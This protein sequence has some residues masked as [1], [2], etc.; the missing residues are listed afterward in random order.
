MED[1]PFT[2]IVSDGHATELFA[3]NP[4][5]MTDY[6]LAKQEASIGF[7]TTAGFHLST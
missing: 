6:L 1:F 5:T 4:I 2:V 7:M 3:L